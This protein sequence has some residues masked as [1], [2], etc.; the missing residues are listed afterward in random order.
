MAALVLRLA[1]LIRDRQPCVALTGAGV[2]TESGIPD[3]R[4]GGGIWAEYDPAEV[5]SIDGFRREPERVWEFYA[6]RLALLADAQPNDAHRALARLEQ[7]GLLEGVITQNVDGLHRRAGS[8]EVLEVHGTVR[9]AVCLACGAR[10][11]H[12][13]VLARLPLPR[14]DCGAVL[15]PAVVMFGELLPADVFARARSWRD[16][17]GCSSSRAR[18]SRSTPSPACRRR[19]LPRAA[20]SRS[21]TATRRRST[22]SP[23]CGSTAARA[24][25]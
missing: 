11:E 24:P 25:S 20:R 15:K 23:S 8:Q 19:R 3:F 6:R 18:R 22:T 17:H 12:E 1:E 21:S 16:V 7:A 9:G 10:A 2:S 14:C 5:A 4:S 13:D